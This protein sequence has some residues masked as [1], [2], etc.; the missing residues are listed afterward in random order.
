MPLPINKTDY[1]QALRAGGLSAELALVHADALEAGL[2]VAIV[3]PAD[4]ALLKA[5]ILA[6]MDERFAE[7]RV[8]V[9][10]QL[11]EKLRPIYAMLGF[12]ACGQ[13]LILFKLFA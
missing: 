4:L 6:R 1:I 12:L 2:D 11:E 3:L 8:W 9:A 13:V 5:E 10:R 7:M